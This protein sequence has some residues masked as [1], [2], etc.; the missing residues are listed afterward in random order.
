MQNFIEL[1]EIKDL[2]YKTTDKEARE[3]YNQISD[4]IF[5][6]EIAD[7]IIDY[8]D[9]IN[10]NQ[11]K[12]KFLEIL[13]KFYN[14]PEIYGLLALA[15]KKNKNFDKA[16]KNINIA[17]NLDPANFVHRYNK[18]I[19]L[20][21]LERFEEALVCF[22]ES[23]QCNKNIDVIFYNK[24]NTYLKLNDIFNAIKSYKRA[25]ELNANFAEAYFNLGIAYEKA[26]LPEEALKCYERACLIEPKNP[27]YEWNKSLMLLYKKNF[28]DGFLAYES[29][30]RKA[31]YKYNLS[32]ERYKGESF[33][34]KTLLVYT[35]QGFGDA[36]LF[37]RLLPDLKKGGCKIILFTHKKL[38]KL[39]KHNNFAD[40]Y[41]DLEHIFTEKVY[42][43]YYV[44]LLSLPAILKKSIF[45][46]KYIKPY[47]FADSSVDN[48][49]K[50]DKSKFNVGIVWKG[51]PE[52]KSNRIRHTELKY[53]ERISK[54]NNVKLYSFQLGAFEDIKNVNF[55]ITDLSLFINDFYDT[56]N[57]LSKIDLLITVD[58][59]ILHLAG[60]MGIN[61]IALLP[62]TLDWRW[63][64]DYG[65]S[66]LYNNIDFIKQDT[67]DNWE[68]VFDILINK[69]E[70]KI[71]NNQPANNIKQVDEENSDLEVLAAN[72]FNAGNYEEAVKYF[73]AYIEKFGN[74]KQ[75][76]NNRGLALQKA[77]KFDDAINDYK[78]AIEIDPEYILARINLVSLLIELQDFSECE[79][80]LNL[81]TSLAGFTKE[82]LF[83]KALFYHKIGKYDEAEKIYSK[84]KEEFDDDLTISLNLGM[85]YNE[86]GHYV[87]AA[88][89]FIEEI[90]KYPNNPELYFHLGNLYI[91]FNKYERAI[92]WF[93][94]SINLN[95]R[96]LEAY[97]NLGL[98]Y[99]NLRKLDEALVLY[100][101]LIKLGFVDYRIY[102]NIG[103]VYYELKDYHKSEEYFKQA[104]QMENKSADLYVAYSETL[105]ML[106]NYNLG[107]NYYGHRVYKDPQLF[108]YINKI[109]ENLDIIKN[110]KIIV[111]GEQ[112]IGDNIMF[113]RYLIPLSEIQE[114]TFLIRKDLYNFFKKVL[115]NYPIKVVTTDNLVNYNCII[116]LLNLPN[117]FST[118]LNS[119][120]SAKYIE[121]INNSLKEIDYYRN[122]SI[123]IGICWKGKEEP[124]HNRKRHMQLEELL[125]IFGGVNLNNTKIISLQYELTESEKE[126]CEN[127]NIETPIYN[128]NDI[129]E[130]FKVIN[131]LDLVITVDTSIAHIASTIGKKTYLMLCYSPDWR[132]GYEGN[133]TDWYST[134]EIF[135]QNKLDIWD[136]VINEINI[137]LRKIIDR[138]EK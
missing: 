2:F 106:G 42:Y 134:I 22:K 8:F 70:E 3:L 82:T 86:I 9:K 138:K 41:Y 136:N 133:K 54:I 28:E 50:F 39:F 97:L 126:I 78:K 12:I 110:K 121:T 49:N 56:A 62:N 76:Y 137:E 19:I 15:Y 51:N 114:F 132:W 31:D 33:F 95:N 113:G 40:E 93:I 87:K 83:L 69:I 6:L 46:K 65:K 74:K 122:D 88:N 119:I 63:N 80:E 1:K 47:I 98:T 35:E 23:A 71:L 18:G 102:Q 75:A 103:I 127:Y 13:L 5:N 29:R 99:F 112:G 115:E 96:Y 66:L 67:D 58:T 27:S 24:G 125:N 11:S 85:L 25:I 60:S 81:L 52:P 130:T 116:P 107:W 20:Y 84:L 90:Q 118:N 129:L 59:A 105:L 4:G 72:Y 38:I 48:S 128:N 68:A 117:L 101:K 30:I 44:S 131:K 100:Q 104:L 17:I 32:G 43:D 77:C 73:S 120:Q 111:T 21:E 91:N 108:S 37:A 45:D 123:K 79:T 53:F 57:L 64:D 89:I 135:R 92:D 34:G 55:D 16:I 109:P 10:D 7:R 94:K 26:K 124:F 36:I 14:N 61:T